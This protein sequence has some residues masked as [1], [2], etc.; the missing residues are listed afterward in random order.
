MKKFLA[1]AVLVFLFLWQFQWVVSLYASEQS[2][3]VDTKDKSVATLSALETAVDG[4]VE[5]LD[6][7]IESKE[8][9]ERLEKKHDEIWEYLEQV[10]QKIQE[11]GSSSEIEEKVQEAKQVVV[12]KVVSW[13]TQ[14]NDSNENISEDIVTSASELREAKEVLQQSLKDEN[15]DYT[16]IVRTKLNQKKFTNIF[17]KLDNK[18]EIEFLY[19]DEKQKYYE[20][21]FT[22]NSLLRQELM[23]DIDQTILP[24]RF[25][26]IEVV[27][28]EIFSVE[29][30][31]KQEQKLLQWENLENTWG[32]REYSSYTYIKDFQKA[33][34]RIKVW[35]I[36]TGIDY[37]HPDLKNRVL[38]NI[39]RDFVNK[40]KDAMDDQWHG[41]HVAGTI[42]A[43]INREGIIGVNPYTKLVP[44]K[45][46]NAS[47]FCPSY[48]VMK[49]LRYAE[50]KKIDIVN[51]S[52][53][54]RWTPTNHPICAAISDYTAKGGMV[55]A[56]AWNANTNANTFIPGGCSDAITVWAY[57]KQWN[58]ASFSNYGTAVDVSAPGVD[59][60]STKLG[61]WYV[62]LS[63]TSMATPHIT[64]IT[65]ILQSYNTDINSQDI[66][67]LFHSAN[68]RVNLSS[69]VNKIQ[70]TSEE[71]EV[72]EKVVVEEKDEESI[73]ENKEDIEQ[74]I[75][76]KDTSFDDIADWVR[77]WNIKGVENQILEIGDL[78]DIL[79]INSGEWSFETI[80]IDEEQ[81]N[82]KVFSKQWWDQFFDLEGNSIDDFSQIQSD[83]EF[84]PVQL[85]EW[86]V[87]LESFPENPFSADQEEVDS[88][89][90]ENFEVQELL[91]DGAQREIN[92]Q[93]SSSEGWGV[94]E[95]ETEED[96]ERRNIDLEI[97]KKIEASFTE[98]NWTWWTTL[99]EN[100]IWIQST[101]NLY[102][103]NVSE[104]QS[105]WEE[106]SSWIRYIRDWANGSNKSTRSHWVELQ[107]IDRNT[108]ENRALWKS[109]IWEY[110]QKSSRYPYTRFTDG[111]ATPKN[112]TEWKSWSR[113]LQVDLWKLYDISEIH[114]W[115]LKWRT[116][117]ETK[118]EVSADGVNWMTIFDSATEGTYKETSEWK[119]HEVNIEDFSTIEAPTN[120]E[121]NHQ[122]NEDVIYTWTDNST[123]LKNELK[124]IL[125]DEN[126]VIIA[127]NILRDSSSYV[128]S[129]L[130]RETTFQRKI[131]A[132]DSYREVCSDLVNFTTLRAV[133]IQDINIYET[134]AYVL[135]NV[136]GRYQKLIYPTKWIFSVDWIWWWAVRIHPI[137]TWVD[138]IT[139]T[140]LQDVAIKRYKVTVLPKPEIQEYM[141]DLH[142]WQ[143]SS[144][145]LP[146]NISLYRYTL[147]NGDPF[148]SHRGRS[149]FEII[150][151]RT[152]QFW[153]HRTGEAV[154][155]LR[156]DYNFIIYRVSISVKLRE[157]TTEIIKTESRDP[158]LS[159]NDRHYS[160]DRNIA[161]VH[162]DD[163]IYW[164]NVWTTTIKSY[165]EWI[166]EQNTYVTVLPIPEPIEIICNIHAWDTCRANKRSDASITYTTS[167]HSA[168]EIEHGRSTVRAKWLAVGT[169]TVYITSADRG[170]IEKIMRVTVLP[171]PPRIYECEIPVGTDCQTLWWER[172]W[173]LK[174]T[175][176]DTSV[177]NVRLDRYVDTRNITMERT[178]IT[179]VSPWYAEVYIYR[180]GDH[181][182]TVQMT[183]NPPVPPISVEDGSITLL[184]WESIEIDIL[185]G[186]GEYRVVEYDADAIY[187]DV[188]N[189]SS[190]NPNVDIKG[191]QVGKTYPV[192]RDKYFQ[193]YRMSINVEDATLELSTDTIQMTGSN[194]EYIT[195]RDYYQDVQV[196]TSNNNVRV[197]KEVIGNNQIA[198]L[199]TPLLW[200]KTTLTFTDNEIQ[201]VDW[202]QVSPNTKTIVVTVWG[203]SGWV[204][205]GFP[206]E[207]ETKFETLFLLDDT[208]NTDLEKILAFNITW[209]YSEVGIEVVNENGEYVRQDIEKSE[210]GFY[211][212]QLDMEV[213]STCNSFVPYFVDFQW[214]ISY[215][216]STW[217]YLWYTEESFRVIALEDSQLW[218]VSQQ[219]NL[220]ILSDQS[221]WKHVQL[222]T[223]DVMVWILLH[224]WALGANFTSDIPFMDT[225]PVSGNML[226][227]Y[228]RWNSQH[229]TYNTNHFISQ[230][231]MKTSWYQEKREKFINMY[232][233]SE[234]SNNINFS[235]I[236]IPQLEYAWLINDTSSR[237]YK[238]FAN[239]FGN[240]NASFY[241]YSQDNDVYLNVTV[242]D[243]YDFHLFNSNWQ[244]IDNQINLWAEY[245]QSR[246]YGK[247]YSWDLYIYDKI[248]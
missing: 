45:I 16:L 14:Y 105:I 154:I 182:Y 52:L 210:D 44:L 83:E 121:V 183:V 230:E 247:V 94:I 162:R 107:A 33:S 12:L 243:T 78:D 172:P 56:A 160:D 24:E 171:E 7:K 98:N 128:E 148:Q 127:D 102:V 181:R 130:P 204:E 31:S 104:E 190:W 214:N 57:D 119:I 166:H 90:E 80:D 185:S 20:L 69:L 196:S 188:D 120:L 6:A 187:F 134:R 111:I 88:E 23:W 39:G 101:D 106:I 9:S 192:F 82:Q 72:V 13:V 237:R 8:A 146:E 42:A 71:E 205:E 161:Y 199:V 63:G 219:N 224:G 173:E 159:A 109:V 151:D 198:F 37:T 74:K 10:T 157:L 108:W 156:D 206:V 177:V 228:L 193:E 50:K 99:K 18:T 15:G 86:E 97:E 175:S 62:N 58:P 22:D 34:K 41:T 77:E 215:A 122:Y 233:N 75:I 225:L 136:T 131:C 38:K 248:N 35:V 143:R 235:K 222:A 135:W 137:T 169:A 27:E 114:V 212:L 3:L 55:I 152:F 46:C 200:W 113:W 132:V 68:K 211:T 36:D 43:S 117:N 87:T 178:R 100:N 96:I 140:D 221:Y 47:G 227:T 145:T 244:Y 138:Y 30:S 174:I 245:Y 124:F 112:W 21:S 180:N 218:V 29:I 59:I 19:T 89:K 149:D 70:S 153:W 191:L 168:F 126:D 207:E 150:W 28:P 197:T 103:N 241:I 40:D 66:K 92:V 220:T 167:R 213:C 93:S 184:Q 84:F 85:T 202:E 125:R 208:S 4:T 242:M 118:T 234:I 61:G 231:L 48:A 81:E 115:H 223:T 139:I 64:G 11:E 65:S 201:E 116:F 142:I 186:W 129:S 170:Y 17:S 246:G 147:S 226:A 195:V 194:P 91:I 5:K 209:T 236:N 54:G 158:W 165:D 232:N 25:L 123:D 49:A 179:W 203:Y 76:K 79:E 164:N 141:I 240:I 239:S 144:I 2:E 238:D 217:N 163:E 155:E 51:M 32:I 1:S 176:T 133:V 67:S 73:V 110:E 216:Q 95:F 53:G 26:G 189:P 229:Q 60:Y